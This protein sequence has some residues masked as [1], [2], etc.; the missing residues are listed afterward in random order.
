VQ[1]FRKDQPALLAAAAHDFRAFAEE[2]LVHREE[3]GYPP[4]G[5]LLLVLVRGKRPGAVK[6]RAHDL[7][8]ELRDLLDPARARV[9]GPAVPPIEKVKDR[10]RRQILVKATDAAEI[11]RAVARLRTERAK[12]RGG[13]EVILDVDPVSMM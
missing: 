6:Q 7:A 4:F 12:T 13:T 9:L 5:R 8:R 3:F 1:T 10:F 11:G 2:E